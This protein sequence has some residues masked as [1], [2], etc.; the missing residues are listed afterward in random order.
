MSSVIRNSA[1]M[2]GDK[3]PHSIMLLLSLAN[4]LNIFDHWKVHSQVLQ[5]Q[6]CHDTP[7]CLLNLSMQVEEA[8]LGKY[9]LSWNFNSGALEACYNA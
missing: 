9:R 1:W 2:Q 3:R 5:T 4:G 8:Q 7:E 6:L